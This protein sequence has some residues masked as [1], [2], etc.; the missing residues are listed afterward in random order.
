MC[1]DC[2]TEYLQLVTNNEIVIRQ[3]RGMD[4]VDVRCVRVSLNLANELQCSI[5][6]QIH[7]NRGLYRDWL[8]GGRILK[9]KRSMYNDCFR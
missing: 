4:V 8:V 2:I 7:R 9:L 1:N 5:E 6:R 3:M